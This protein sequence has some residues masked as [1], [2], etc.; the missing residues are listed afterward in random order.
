MHE[1][2]TSTSA[3][4]V[5]LAIEL[6]NMPELLS[7]MKQKLAV[8][9]KTSDLFNSSKFARSIEQLYSKM[10]E[11]RLAGFGAEVIKL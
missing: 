6:G 2:I 5:A 8:Q 4:Y 11:R 3:D 7:A 9:I 10:H 1:L